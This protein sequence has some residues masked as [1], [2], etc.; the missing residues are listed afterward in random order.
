MQANGIRVRA[1]CARKYHIDYDDNIGMFVRAD[2]GQM[3]HRCSGP[4]NYPRDNVCPELR[5]EKVI[6]DGDKELHIIGE[7][8]ATILLL[9][10]DLLVDLNKI[11]FDNCTITRPCESGISSLIEDVSIHKLDVEDRTGFE[12]GD[13]VR[14]DK[15]QVEA[16][17]V[18]NGKGSYIIETHVGSGYIDRYE[19][20]Q[21]CGGTGK[22]PLRRKVR[23]NDR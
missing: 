8:N 21:A 18:C 3:P 9:K 1:Y 20:C 12:D 2:N 13:R 16:C 15:P 10:K 19:D 14:L 11:R 4:C 22:K 17:P 6:I 23:N 5:F 7:P